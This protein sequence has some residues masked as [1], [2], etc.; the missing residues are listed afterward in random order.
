MIDPKQKESFNYLVL[1]LCSGI[2]FSIFSMLMIGHFAKWG[3]EEGRSTIVE[4][5]NL[6]GKFEY[7]PEESS[8]D[9][10]NKLEV[11]SCSKILDPKILDPK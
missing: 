1:G 9:K 3:L 11:Y 8:S 5:C 7:R 6:F 10:P 2:L 4:R